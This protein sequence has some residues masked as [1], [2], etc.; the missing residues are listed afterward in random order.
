MR[1]RTIGL[2][3]SILL[4][5]LLPLSLSGQEYVGIS[6]YS[7]LHPRFPCAEFRAHIR[8]IAHPAVAILFGT[9]GADTTCL[10]DSLDDMANRPHILEI[11]F[12]NESARRMHRPFAGELLPSYGV[13][14]LNASLKFLPSRV[15]KAYLKRLNAIFQMVAEVSNENTQILL[16]FGLEDNYNIRAFRQLEGILRP[17]VPE[18]ITLVRST[19][20]AAEMDNSILWETHRG[21]VRG[22]ANNSTTIVNPDGFVLNK[23]DYASLI[24]QCSACKVVYYWSVKLQGRGNAKFT[25]PRRRHFMF[26]LKDRQILNHLFK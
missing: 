22:T 12:S 6:A 18:T 7:M 2:S 20:V 4:L 3:F 24:A 17:L 25:P 14:R 11:H 1:T 16:S 15:M 26:T 19:N 21:K 23:K 8:K 13:A 9:F 10:K 5:L